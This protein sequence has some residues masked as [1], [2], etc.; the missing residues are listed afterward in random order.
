M[1][2]VSGWLSDITIFEEQGAEA[3]SEQREFMFE[4]EETVYSLRI[5]A[6]GVVDEQLQK[7]SISAI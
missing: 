2:G 4:K 5:F 3:L 1:G 7:I 6:Q